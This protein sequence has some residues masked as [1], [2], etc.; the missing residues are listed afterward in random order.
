MLFGA[1]KDFPRLAIGPVLLR[2]PRPA[3]GIGEGPGFM[4]AQVVPL[5]RLVG[6]TKNPNEKVFARIQLYNDGQGSCYW[7]LNI[8]LYDASAGNLTDAQQIANLGGNRA[9]YIRHPASG[10]SGPLSG[11]G[12][13]TEAWV[14]LGVVPIGNV[15]NYNCMIFAVPFDSA[16]RKLD[17][18]QY[19]DRKL[20]TNAVQMAA[21]TT[22]NP[23]LRLGYVSFS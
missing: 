10:T 20:V 6:V 22:A 12:A 5:P 13:M 4:G 14:D 21:V 2:Y 7:V 9:R 1:R 19:G 17:E 18:A 23:K 3:W 16:G 8:Y 11:N 15:R